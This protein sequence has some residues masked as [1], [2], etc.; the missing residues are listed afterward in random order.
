MCPAPQLCP[1]EGLR[2]G[3]LRVLSEL[4]AGPPSALSPL[5]TQGVR[6]DSTELHFM[7]TKTTMPPSRNCQQHGCAQGFV[8]IFAEPEGLG[9][10]YDID[11][12][13]SLTRES[14]APRPA[15]SLLRPLGRAWP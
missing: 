12:D 11:L 6:P 4:T 3:R 2:A 15:G 7:V 8:P 13:S 5:C 10:L 1:W 9:R 14:R